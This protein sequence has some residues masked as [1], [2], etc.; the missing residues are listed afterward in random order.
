MSDGGQLAQAM[1]AWSKKIHDNAREKGFWD[2]DRNMGE[3]VALCHSELSELLEGLRHGDPPSDKI[4]EFSSAE[5]EAADL[6]IRVMDMA[7]YCGWRLGEA[8]VAKHEHNRGR[9][10]MHGGKLF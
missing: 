2:Q 1:E 6:I 7:H 9:T 8:I 10:K 4:P 3:F 5:E